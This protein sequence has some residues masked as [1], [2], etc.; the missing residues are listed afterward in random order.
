MSSF[1]SSVTFFSHWIF[2]FSFPF[3]SSHLLSADQAQCSWSQRN[4]Q[5][6]VRECTCFFVLSTSRVCVFMSSMWRRGGRRRR[7]RERRGGGGA[8]VASGLWEAGWSASLTHSTAPA[9]L[10]V[11]INNQSLWLP[12]ASCLKSQSSMKWPLLNYWDGHI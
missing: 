2:P 8:V 9:S 1:Q 10:G 4:L 12:R 11:S 6:Y 7:R 3:K 5:I